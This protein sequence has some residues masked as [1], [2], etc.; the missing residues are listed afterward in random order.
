MNDG[1]VRRKSLE[2][3]QANG[4]PQKE[5]LDTPGN[6]G[7]NLTN[8]RCQL[9]L[10][11]VAF[12]FV[13]TGFGGAQNLESSLDLG[14]VSGSVCLGIIYVVFTVTCMLAPVVVR[15][16]SPKKTMMLQF[17]IFGLFVLSN[18]WPEEWT[19]YPIS[20]LVGFF[21]APMWV[22]Q[23]QYVTTLAERQS[24]LTNVDVYGTFNGIFYSIFQLQQIS[25]NLISA[26]VL[27][28]GS[29]DSDD[30]AWITKF[31]L[32]VSFGA[33]C[34]LGLLVLY[35]WVKRLEPEDLRKPG[36]ETCVSDKAQNTV[37][38]VEGEQ[39]IWS[40]FRFMTYPQ[41]F[42]LIPIMLA[43]GLEM[44]FAYSTLTGDVI[45]GNLG[46]DNIGWGMIVFG[47]GCALSS[48]FFGKVSDKLGPV[49][50][51]T[52]AF[53][54][55]SVCIAYLYFC[56]EDLEPYAWTEIFIVCGIWGICDGIMQTLMS[57][58]LGEW[59]TSEKEDAFANWKTW[60][61][62]GM[63]I[64][65]FSEDSVPLKSLL[66]LLFF[67]WCIGIIGLYAARYLRSKNRGYHPIP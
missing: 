49:F 51:I 50:C 38:A 56:Y 20:G 18:I 54:I 4:E 15:Y 33:C 37:Q 36:E 61:S 5:S 21:Y 47:V 52:I 58:L 46:T 16:L 1:A 43:N 8:P 35:I 63:S 3:S 24:L 2:S 39:D 67:V 23:G 53:I 13:F 60:Q 44:G 9:I 7:L 10:L 45:A 6:E 25:G 17:F 32:F 26:L 41:L 22:A 30:I 65:F 59:F 11:A 40:A 29:G 12:F 55:E 66:I 31:I 57:A 42:L 48:F 62:G 19:M 14:A 64:I 28:T 27:D 34:W